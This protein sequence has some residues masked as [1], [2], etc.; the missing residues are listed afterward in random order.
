MYLRLF[1]SQ[2]IY[3]FIFILEVDRLV[4]EVVRHLWCGSLR[5]CVHEHLCTIFRFFCPDSE[6]DTIPTALFTR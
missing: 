5:I 1:V 6:K 2:K 4:L 3:V